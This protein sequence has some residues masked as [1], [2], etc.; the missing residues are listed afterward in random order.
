MKLKSSIRRIET[1]AGRMRV[2]ILQPEDGKK[3]RPGILW[4]HGGGY[5]SGL[6]AMV[7]V[8]MGRTLAKHFGGVV[9]SPDYRKATRAPYPAALEDCHAALQ[10]LYDRAEELGVDRK[11]IIVGGESAG[12]GLAAAVCIYARDKG[13]VPVSFQIPLYPMLDCEDTESSRRSHSHGWGTRRNHLGWRVYLREL[14]GTDRVPPY[15]SP[16]R[17]TDFAGLPPC[18]TYVED[19]EPFRDETAA[20]VRKLQEAGVE[21]HMDIFHGNIHGFDVM[22]WTKNAK[23]AKRRLIAAAEKYMK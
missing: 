3:L 2:L 8:T 11:R 7:Y 4:I 9:L 22:A 13:S 12:G 19:G 23:E 16:S 5:F 6:A 1:P 10:Y 15:A 20:Y 17:E 18:Y 14:Y 21:A